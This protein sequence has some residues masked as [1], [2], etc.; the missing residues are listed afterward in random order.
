MCH[1]EDRLRSEEDRGI[2]SMSGSV[3]FRIELVQFIKGPWMLIV[4]HQVLSLLIT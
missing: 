3:E 2:I 1:N 4:S